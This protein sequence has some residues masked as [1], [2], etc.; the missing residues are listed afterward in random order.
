MR[1]PFS[2]S[3]P[4][5][6]SG[7]PASRKARTMPVEP[8]WAVMPSKC[9]CTAM[10]SADTFWAVPSSQ[11][12]TTSTVLK[13]L[14]EAFSVSCRPLCRS[15]S[16][17]VPATPRTSRMSPPL[18]SFLTSQS[19]QYLPR[20]SW[21]TLTLMASSVSSVLSKAT[22]TTPAAWARLTTER[23][24]VGFWASMMTAS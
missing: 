7:A 22:S 14:P 13:V 20:P 23:K 2:V 1:K 17:E 4:A 9:L 15:V 19:P 5:G 3:A 24:A 11:W 16:T 21:S 8:P 18:G 12:P 10:A 6:T